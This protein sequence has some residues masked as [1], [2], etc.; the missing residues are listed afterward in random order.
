M[1]Q[2]ISVLLTIPIV[3]GCIW[4]TSYFIGPMQ[5][6]DIWWYFTGAGA[7]CLLAI[8]DKMMEAINA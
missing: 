2:F 3:L 4:G 5:G 6:N 7:V 1:N 8:K